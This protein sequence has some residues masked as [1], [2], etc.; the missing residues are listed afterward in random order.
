MS[1]YDINNIHFVQLFGRQSKQTSTQ[2]CYAEVLDQNK[3]YT[4]VEILLSD[5]ALVVLFIFHSF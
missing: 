5:F 4:Y 2:N 1:L 3:F